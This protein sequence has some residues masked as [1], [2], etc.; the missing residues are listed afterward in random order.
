M[1][2]FQHA[3]LLI[4]A[5]ANRPDIKIVLSMSWV[6]RLGFDR[7][8]SYLPAELGER[9]IVATLRRN[10]GVIRTTDFSFLDMYRSRATSCG[11]G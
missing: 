9:V 2:F 4:E 6:A 8:K 3:P 11:I 10:A 5:L 1:A 7:A